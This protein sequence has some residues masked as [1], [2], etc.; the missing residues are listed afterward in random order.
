MSI[1]KRKKNSRQR[2]SKTHGWGSMKKHRGA[3]N[4]GGRGMAGSGKRGD[5]I[6]PR[7][8]DKKYFG[9]SGFKKKNVGKKV[10]AASIG[11][12]ED[13]LDSFLSKKLIS[14]EGDSYIVDMGKIGFNK[15]LSQRKVSNKFKIKVD[16]A[17]KK[18]VEKIK[19]KGGEVVLLE[20]ESF[21]K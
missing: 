20:K 16:Y 8:W 15:L 14:K 13:K 4:R 2:G 7:L 19:N 10:N 6:K 1:S 9:K 12:L 3:G 21:F 18:A 17:S 11:Y 5:T